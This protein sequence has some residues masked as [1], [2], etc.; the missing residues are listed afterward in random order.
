MERINRK[1]GGFTLIELMI[2]VAIIGILA[3]VAI[4]AYQ[5][6]V[7]KARIS[8]VVSLAAGAKVTIGEAMSKIGAMPAA[9]AV[10]VNALDCMYTNTNCVGTAANAT[11]YVSAFVWAVADVAPGTAN[12]GQATLT[13]RNIGP[14]VDGT[15]LLISYTDTGTGYTMT[16]AAGAAN[17][18]PAQFIPAC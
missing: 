8:E 17:P 3:A 14:G 2:V 18:L 4:P 13:L 10:E 11:D 5:D 6:Y 15:T 7:K 9:G 1:Q 12:S 16:C